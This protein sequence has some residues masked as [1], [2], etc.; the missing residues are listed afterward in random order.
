MNPVT[1]HLIH[2]YGLAALA[3]LL[4]AFCLFPRLTLWLWSTLDFFPYTMDPT[5]TL[6]H[7]PLKGQRLA[8]VQ[9]IEAL[10]LYRAQCPNITQAEYNSV[11]QRIR[12]LHRA[13]VQNTLTTRMIAK[14]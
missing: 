14:P 3:L 13:G 11:G 6:R 2:W 7:G 9:S 10:I 5:Y 8:D 4:G 12:E 1:L